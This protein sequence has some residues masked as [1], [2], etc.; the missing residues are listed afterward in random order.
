M[1]RLTVLSLLVGLAVVISA[2]SRP[3]PQELSAEDVTAIRA[4]L[5]EDYCNALLTQDREAL[6][7][8]YTEQ[9]V[10]MVQ[11]GNS[12]V[13]KPN[14]RYRWR[15][16]PNY[17]FPKAIINPT[18]IAGYGVIACAV[19]RFDFAWHYSGATELTTRVGTWVFTLR[20]QE[21]SSWK[22]ALSHWVYD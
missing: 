20:K 9:A 13:G 19:C 10:E 1:R 3:A 21:D 12:F 5:S 18:D 14:L 15:E 2:A 22:I 11:G 6:M 4:V 17:D 8:C 7:A 16:M